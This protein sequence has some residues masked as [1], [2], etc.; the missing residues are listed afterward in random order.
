MAG[1]KTQLLKNHESTM[2]QLDAKVKR[3]ALE[4]TL[5]RLADEYFSQ[6]YGK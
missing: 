2:E 6:R 1:N 5:F 4:S 3:N